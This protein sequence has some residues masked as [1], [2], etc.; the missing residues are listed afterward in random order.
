MLKWLRTNKAQEAGQGLVEYALILSLVAVVGIAGAAA[1]GG[2]V[3]E[4]YDDIGS[5]L[6]FAPSDDL[7]EQPG[8]EQLGGGEQGDEQ[9]EEEE[10]DDR[11]EDGVPDGNDNCPDTANSSQQDSDQDGAG[12]VCDY[13][14]FINI[15]TAMPQRDSYGNLW[16][17]EYGLS[18]TGGGSI[19][20]DTNSRDIAR[21]SEDFIFQSVAYSGRGSRGTKLTW[22]TTDLPEGTYTVT[23]YFVEVNDRNP[24]QFDV[25]VQGSTKV[26][27]YRPGDAGLFTASQVRVSDVEVRNGRLEI[28]LHPESG[29]PSLAGI[30]LNGQP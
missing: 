25:Q 17:G 20:R 21:T 26:R 24:G 4:V 27:S 9:E 2:A 30:Q 23:L 1:T 8:D 5:A 14:H 10:H 12:D 22:L 3:Q 19:Y 11:D 15:G 13:T 29:Y 16:V 28:K 6:G 18:T 7:G